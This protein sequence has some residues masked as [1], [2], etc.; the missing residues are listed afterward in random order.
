[1]DC[2]VLPTGQKMFSATEIR[3]AF[4]AQPEAGRR[5]KKI[6]FRAISSAPALRESVRQKCGHIFPSASGNRRSTSRCALLP[7]ASDA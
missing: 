1:M 6:F 2:R 7:L 5:N 3:A 4:G